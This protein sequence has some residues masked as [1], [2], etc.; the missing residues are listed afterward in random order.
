MDTARYVV[1]VLLVVGLPPAIAF[2]LLI[3]PVAGWWRRV[4]PLV[5]YLVVGGACVALGCGGWVLRKEVMGSDLG[6]RWILM[7]AAAVLYLASAWLSVLAKRHLKMK[8]FAGFPEVAVEES[9]GVLLQEGIYAVIRHPR[10]VAVIV[11]TAGVALFVNYV[12]IYLMVLGT[13]PALYLVGILEE[14]ELAQRFGDPYTAY[15]SRVPAFIPRIL[16]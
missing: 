12:G 9:G 13:I 8:I 16:R 4:G 7:P 14:R 15:R 10:Y 2:W 6:T 3:H 11:G 5:T 1:G